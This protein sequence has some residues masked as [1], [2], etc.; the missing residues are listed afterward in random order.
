MPPTSIG[1]FEWSTVQICTILTELS[2][3]V[4][5]LPGYSGE[6]L[7]AVSA[8]ANLAWVTPRSRPR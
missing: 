3:R 2:Y 4:V 7:R 6:A 1:C 5:Q 8:N